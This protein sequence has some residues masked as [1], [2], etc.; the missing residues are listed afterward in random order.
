ME[1]ERLSD[2]VN[3]LADAASDA[4]MPHFRARGIVENKEKDHFDP[5]TAADREAEAAMRR[6]IETTYPGHGIIGEEYGDDRPDSEYVWVLDPIDGTRAFVTGLPTWGTLI[7]LL[8]Q[9][10][11][12]FG[13]DVSAF[14][15]RALFRRRAVGVV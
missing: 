13:N 2:F 5:V 7:G 1:T 12:V 4:I 8:H 10:E 14:H 6:M 9:G 3:G 11:P 15:R